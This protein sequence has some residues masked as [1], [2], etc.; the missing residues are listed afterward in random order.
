MITE[1]ALPAIVVHVL[2]A[3]ALGFGQS[4][5][6]ALVSELD[7]NARGA[8]L[9]LNSSAMYAGMVSATA[10]S[11]ALLQFGSFLSI[12]IMCAV[13]ALAVLPITSYLVKEHEANRSSMA[14]ERI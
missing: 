3:T 14:A 4:A 5:L 2:S 10:I 9:A 1:H 6:T 11:A 8:V 7:P 13:A 12:G